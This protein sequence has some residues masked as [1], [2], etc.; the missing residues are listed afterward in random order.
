[1]KFREFISLVMKTPGAFICF[2]FVFMFALGVGLGMFAAFVF[3]NFIY[4]VKMQKVL[5][6]ILLIQDW[7]A[8]GNQSSK[9]NPVIDPLA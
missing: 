1:M 5:P 2:L 3:E 8:S 4:K 6:V 7:R 9:L